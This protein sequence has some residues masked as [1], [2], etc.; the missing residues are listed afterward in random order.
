MEEKNYRKYEIS[1]YLDSEEDFSQIKSILES[2]GAINLTDCK[3]EKMQLS[4]PIKKRKFA[5]FGSLNFEAE[6]EAIQNVKNKLDIEKKL[7]R[8]MILRVE[9]FHQKEQKSRSFKKMADGGSENRLNG[10]SVLTNEVLEKKI[11]E[12]LG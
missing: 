6:P 5:F 11:E 4:Y 10:G 9:D 8:Y 12:I 1:F 2:G 3:P 7:I